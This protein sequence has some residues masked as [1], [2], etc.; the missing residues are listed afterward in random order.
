MKLRTMLL[1]VFIAGCYML[2]DCLPKASPQSTG[3]ERNRT[4]VSYQTED[5]W[6]I[7]GTLFFPQT[8]SPMPVPGVVIL[9]EP[10]IRNQDTHSGNLARAVNE[11]GMVALTIDMRGNSLSYGKKDFEQFSLKDMEG[12]R[13]DI[14]GAVDYLH[15]RKE[16]D[17]RRLVIAAS[18][19]TADYAVRAAAERPDLI[20]AIVLASA[21][22]LGDESREYISYRRTLPLLVLVGDR[23]DRT[24]QKIAAE[25]YF[26]SENRDSKVYFGLDRGAGMFNRPPQVAEKVATWLD[27]NVTGLGTD[28]EISFQSEDGWPLRG[29]LL[30]PANADGNSKV[31]G[32]VFIHGAH[33]DQQGFY[34]LAR[35]VVK[36]GMAA[37]LFDGRGNRKSVKPD[38]EG[39]GGGATPAK[40]AKAAIQFMANQGRVDASKITLV[41]A[42]A[43]C[44][45]TVRASMGDPR[46]KGIVA[47]SFYNPS[48]EVK[49]YL[50]TSDV[51]LFLLATVNDINADG[52]S[53][54]EGTKE[55]YRLSK[56]KYT[57]LLLLDDAG[58]GA[59]ML[60]EKPELE[61][62]IVRWLSARLE[63]EAVARKHSWYE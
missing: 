30:M 8:A 2:G 29:N 47:M 12:F 24:V 48:P 49:Q 37:L 39:E 10:G 38:A 61:P 16:V 19:I 5:G 52:S 31:P 15:S 18:G 14:L 36:M 62:V 17:G 6:I 11:R 25:P 43:A 9:S 13:L 56:S 20:Q 35:E 22:K 33:H 3:G 53:L 51:P 34:F 63:S 54:D 4:L 59:N 45:Q 55:V 57:D 23:E 60:H 28:T 46:I 21:H 58:R 1:S 41:T 32:V 50:T 42:T 26:L 27:D 44:E 7:H 40:D